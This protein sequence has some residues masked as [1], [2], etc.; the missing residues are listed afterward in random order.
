MNRSSFPFFE[1]LRV[2]YSE[3]DAQGIVFNAHYLT[4]FDV[5]LNE[6][7]RWID[8][9]YHKMLKQEGLDFH[10]IKSTVEYLA[11]IHFDEDIEIGVRPKKVGNTSLTWELG[12]FHKDQDKCLALG[13]IIWVCAV[14]GSH[15]SHPLPA[16]LVTKVASHE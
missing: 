3:I 2:R 11:P 5:A 10:L 4:Y 15:K 7:L 6:Y 14:S 8:F 1:P 13:E 9:D 12:I 16:D